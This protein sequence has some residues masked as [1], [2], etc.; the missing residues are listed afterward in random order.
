MKSASDNERE[1]FE[2]LRSAVT[3]AFEELERLRAENRTLHAQL[4]A[5]TNGRTQDP[6]DAPLS[7]GKPNAELRQ[8][9]EAYVQAIDRFIAHHSGGEGQEL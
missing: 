5:A 8:E 4:A 1:A 6:A 2:A 9:I 7:F 3:E